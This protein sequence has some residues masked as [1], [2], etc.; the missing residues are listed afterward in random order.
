MQNSQF[1]L[2]RMHP[3]QRLLHQ[4]SVQGQDGHQPV[5]ST[6]H[7]TQGQYNQVS[8]QFKSDVQAWKEKNDPKA[9]PPVPQPPTTLAAMYR[10]DLTQKGRDTI[11]QKAAPNILGLE[12]K[13]RMLVTSSARERPE[14][15]S[16]NDFT[17]RVG[18]GVLGVPIN[19]V[20]LIG[21]S[22]PQSEFAV[23]PN[24]T[25][26]PF[27]YGWCAVPRG[28][29]YGLR[30][31]TLSNTAYIA[32]KGGFQFDG[33]P[34]FVLAELPLVRNPIT[35]IRRLPDALEVTC[36][37]RIGSRPSALGQILLDGLWTPIPSNTL[38]ETYLVKQNTIVEQD[39]TGI[40][41]LT[42]TLPEDEALVPFRAAWEPDQDDAAHILVLRDPQLLEAFSDPTL[43]V[44]L[45]PQHDLVTSL[46]TVYV[47]PC[48]SGEELA[49]QLSKQLSS[50]SQ[51][52]HA[53]P[54]PSYWPLQDIR[55]DRQPRS[56]RFTLHVSWSYATRTDENGAPLS[57]YMDNLARGY[58]RDH[59]MPMLNPVVT[60]VGD[61]LASRFSLP[62]ATGPD[63][64]SESHALYTA[65][66]QPVLFHEDT[67]MMP[68]VAAE[69]DAFWSGVNVISKSIAFTATSSSG[70]GTGSGSP[71][72][73]SKTFTIPFR[74]G[75]DSR[76]LY[77][78]VPEG[79]YRPWSL[80]VQI[81][82][83]IRNV[84]PLRALGIVCVPRFSERSPT[85]LVGFRFESMARPTPYPFDLAFD[86]VNQENQAADPDTQSSPRMR[87]I[88]PTRL[89][90]LPLRYTGRTVYDPVEVTG[91]QDPYLH[92]GTPVT[93][94]AAELG[95]GVPSPLPFV[96]RI[97]PVS[98]GTRALITQDAYAPIDVER[99]LLPAHAHPNGTAPPVHVECRTAALF[100]H[101]QPVHINLSFPAQYLEFNGTR[102]LPRAYNI[103]DALFPTAKKEEKYLLTATSM[104]PLGEAVD[105]LS[106]QVPNPAFEN[107]EETA[108]D[109]DT[110]VQVFTTLH[111]PTDQASRTLVE[112]LI[113]L[114]GARRRDYGGGFTGPS[115]ADGPVRT[116]LQTHAIE[117]MPTPEQLDQLL[118]FFIQGEHMHNTYQVLVRVIVAFVQIQGLEDITD[119]A[120]KQVLRIVKLYQ[121][122][123]MD[124][125][126]AGDKIYRMI[127]AFAEANGVGHP[128][129]VL[130][131]VAETVTDPPV[132]PGDTLLLVTDDP[133]PAASPRPTLSKV[134]VWGREQSQDTAHR[135]SNN[136]WLVAVPHNV[137]DT[138]LQWGSMTIPIKPW[139]SSDTLETGR[140][141]TMALD[142]RPTVGILGPVVEHSGGMYSFRTGFDT[143]GAIADTVTNPTYSL[144]L[145]D[146]PTTLT[147]KMF[148]IA[149]KYSVSIPAHVLLDLRGTVR[150]PFNVQDALR[151]LNIPYVDDTQ[152]VFDLMQQR[153]PGIEGVRQVTVVPRPTY[154]SMNIGPDG[155]P[156]PRVQIMSVYYTL[157]AMANSPATTRTLTR[158][159]EHPM[160]IDFA[161][162]SDYK[163]RPERL[164]FQMREY[165]RVQLSRP[166]DTIIPTYRIP[167]TLGS[168]IDVQMES[169]GYILLS[170]SING[171]TT[172]DT[173]LPDGRMATSFSDPND[174]SRRVTHA[175]AHSDNIISV[176][177]SS[178]DGERKIVTATAYVMLSERQRLLDRQ[179]DRVYQQIPTST[180]VNTIRIRAYR[181]DGTLY[182]F[183]G[184][185]ISVMLRFTTHKDNP[186]FV[187]QSRDHA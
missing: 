22:L 33:T 156:P 185:E 74:L 111:D 72:S 65:R 144:S 81:T 99:V 117:S 109:L 172:N 67:V 42:H 128:D 1:L 57:A 137:R 134:H 140:V 106:M 75:H 105:G 146:S 125:S 68:P 43:D 139:T 5:L 73:S 59:I 58:T 108:E 164:G 96:P 97:F 167:Q 122:P 51:W 107:L 100:Y 124:P 142:A 141:Y 45:D 30:V 76:V 103:N 69:G 169:K 62:D 166:F 37:R 77:A 131:Y 64:W 6:P 154:M 118:T 14:E 95:N 90:F 126:R 102:G 7:I 4:V 25:A 24:E 53:R 123:D 82:R 8:K 179:E 80:A 12:K 54:G 92:V 127:H 113:A 63:S 55:I 182:N 121:G 41:V 147:A 56:G 98:N 155:K 40:Y 120:R 130:H 52:R 31:N 84:P 163:L 184:R 66:D 132:R 70:A 145:R 86:V 44:R 138:A 60:A 35:R 49:R 152:A 116:F 110:V 18:T 180:F 79:E 114:L 88:Q 11:L 26:L 87:V 175:D 15:T 48:A 9:P 119:P 85:T 93:F 149:N 36:A 3:S 171:S 13:Y 173:V 29:L 83:A 34:E 186:S 162:R 153:D 187:P 50:L 159:L 47:P 133:D 160:S 112:S 38:P 104:E 89:G 177:A 20:E 174:S 136:Q 161:S 2:R 21:Y 17:V 183:H 10:S 170:I 181:P 143:Q 165:A 158:D 176:S 178:M 135:L 94:P 61:T 115:D 16:T 150:Y 168:V 157:L 39:V 71:P 32:G 27:R 91:G 23:E 78:T 129:R 151:D 101:L 148:L 46:G 28:R 19:G